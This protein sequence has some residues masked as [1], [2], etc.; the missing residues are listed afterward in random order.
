LHAIAE[1]GQLLLLMLLEGIGVVKGHCE[2]IFTCWYKRRRGKKTKREKRKK[3]M[4]RN[5]KQGYDA[6]VGLT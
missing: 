2:S 3:K 1:T 6:R 5:R 4:D